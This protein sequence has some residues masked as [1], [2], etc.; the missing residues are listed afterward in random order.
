MYIILE[1][2][3]H[4]QLQYANIY[5][6]KSWIGG[7]LLYRN[8]ILCIVTFLIILGRM[9]SMP[10]ACSGEDFKKSNWKA[11][12]IWMWTQIVLDGPV[13]AAGPRSVG[14]KKGPVYCKFKTSGVTSFEVQLNSREIYMYVAHIY[15]WFSKWHLHRF[16]LEISI[17][18]EKL[19]GI[20]AQFFALPKLTNKFR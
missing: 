12:V 2:I 19:A 17:I 13:P 18:I 16:F 10:R 7:I 6:Q 1:P 4:H 14:S 3:N 5:R 15:V 9:L 11:F 8:S 20:R